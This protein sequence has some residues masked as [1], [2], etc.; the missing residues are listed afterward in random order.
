MKIEVF[1]RPDGSGF[2]PARQQKT[3]K[4]IAKHHVQT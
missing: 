2:A 1:S 3:P 4:L